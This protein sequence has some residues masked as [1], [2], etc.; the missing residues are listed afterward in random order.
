MFRLCRGIAAQRNR[1]ASTS[2]TST[3]RAKGQTR[4]AQEV[5]VLYGSDPHTCPVRAL[6]TWL[7]TIGKLKKIG[8]RNSSAELR[9]QRHALTNPKPH[10]AQGR[11]KSIPVARRYIRP[12][13]AGT[14]MRAL[15][16]GSNV[17]TVQRPTVQTTIRD[18]ISAI[19]CF[20]R[21]TGACLADRLSGGGL[22]LGAQ[23][24]PGAGG[25]LGTES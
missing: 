22:I 20:H 24:Y 2:A 10:H 18:L 7:A 16:S 14:I 3:S 17:E 11:W 8:E 9:P 6:Q 25:L 15:A 5:A 23:S 4:R 13:R 1:R 12:S 21:E 19:L